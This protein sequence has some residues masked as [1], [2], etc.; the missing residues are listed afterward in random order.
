[1]QSSPER[2]RC[3]DDRMM[4]FQLRAQGGPSL[5]RKQDGALTKHTPTSAWRA[6]RTGLES[7]VPISEQGCTWKGHLTSRTPV[8]SL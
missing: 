1:M 7:V 6:E 8:S 2:E 5:P 3:T 4:I